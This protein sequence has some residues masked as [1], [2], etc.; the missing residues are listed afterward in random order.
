MTTTITAGPIASC[1]ANVERPLEPGL[2]QFSNDMAFSHCAILPVDTAN[3]RNMLLVVVPGGESIIARV[4][5]GPLTPEQSIAGGQ[6]LPLYSSIP[7]QMRGQVGL[8]TGT[9]MMRAWNVE[10]LLVQERNARSV[11]DLPPVVREFA[12]GLREYARNAR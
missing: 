9:E 4:A 6:N 10:P 7:R 3:C 8:F 1:P 5:V 2:A 11:S 12:E